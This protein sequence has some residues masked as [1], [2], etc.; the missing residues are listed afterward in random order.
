MEIER[1]R[2]EGGREGGKEE[3]CSTEK[4]G[5]GGGGGEGKEVVMVVVSGG[6]G[7][8]ES[9]RVVKVG[10]TGLACARWRGRGGGGWRY[11]TPGGGRGRHWAGSPPNT[12]P[13]QLCHGHWSCRSLPA[14]QQDARSGVVEEGRVTVRMAR[15]EILCKHHTVTCTPPRWF[16]VTQSPPLYQLHHTVP[17]PLPA[18]SPLSPA[19]PP[20]TPPVPAS[21]PA[22][23]SRPPPPPL[24]YTFPNTP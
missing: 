8:E 17:S 2:E 12:A 23:A 11:C 10:L 18:T 16:M 1:R 7:G 4:S 20:P 19:S 6:R 13:D 14:S 15:D 3:F 21:P 24:L 22:P 9:G 5:K